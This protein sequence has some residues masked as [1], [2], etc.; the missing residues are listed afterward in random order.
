MR[1]SERHLAGHFDTA[2]DQSRDGRFRRAQDELG[3][4]NARAA[5]LVARV[6]LHAFAHTLGSV[7]IFCLYWSCV[8]APVAAH[9]LIYLGSATAI[10]LSSD[11]AARLG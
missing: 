5:V 9:A 3:R 11:G 10:I 6:A 8:G 1:L 2:L 4:R 7:G